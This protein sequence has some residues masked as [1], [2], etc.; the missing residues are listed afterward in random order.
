[1]TV[2]APSDVR[3]IT[4]PEHFGGCGAEHSAGELEPGQ[5]MSIDCPPCELALTSPPLSAHGWSSREDGVA[6]TPD[7]RQ[8]LESQEKEGSAATALMVK[9]LGESLA[10]AVRLGNLGVA[11]LPTAPA[12]PQFVQPSAD[13]IHSALKEMDPADLEQLLRRAGL[14]APVESAD[15][16]SAPAPDPEPVKTPAK[17]TAAKK[18]AAKAPAADGAS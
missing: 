2:H 16:D 12:Q 18:T 5:R 8:L 7:E 4:V 11:A 10:Q 13:D 3:S 15:A 9:Q 17:A 14:A 1:M 6:L